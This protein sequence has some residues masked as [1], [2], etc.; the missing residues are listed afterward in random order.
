MM[1][2][3]RGAAWVA[4]G[5]DRFVSRFKP[6]VS[7]VSVPPALGD[8]IAELR[9]ECERFVDQRVAEVAQRDG[10]GLPV[11]SVRQLVTRGRNPF[12]AAEAL[13]RE[14]RR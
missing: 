5:E 10:L 13:L 3:N 7:V 2:A 11:G 14:V 1:H 6:R 9:A 12:E 4:A 8:R